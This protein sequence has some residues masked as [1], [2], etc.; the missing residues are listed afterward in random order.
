MG[1]RGTTLSVHL[2]H[3]TPATPAALATAA[4]PADYLPGIDTNNNYNNNTTNKTVT[5]SSA[6]FA[7]QQRPCGPAAGQY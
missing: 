1:K 4:T 2:L 7:Q 3:A 5:P 6:H